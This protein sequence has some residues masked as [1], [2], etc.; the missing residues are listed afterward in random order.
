MQEIRQVYKA[1]SACFLK[2]CVIKLLRKIKIIKTFVHAQK[3]LL[4]LFQT[5]LSF[6]SYPRASNC[7]LVS[8]I[9]RRKSAHVFVIPLSVTQAADI[10][11]KIRK[12]LLL[13]H[14]Q[15]P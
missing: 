4:F 6:A 3:F 12:R 9:A 14:K 13:N 2:A 15:R 1:T 10:F 8:E 11:A 7:P 5:T